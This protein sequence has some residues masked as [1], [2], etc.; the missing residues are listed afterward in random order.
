MTQDFYVKVCTTTAA[1]WPSTLVK[2]I[3]LVDLQKQL[4]CISNLKVKLRNIRGPESLVNCKSALASISKNATCPNCRWMATKKRGRVC[5]EGRARQ[6]GEQIP[7]GG[8][9]EWNR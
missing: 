9:N 6:D 3:T 7:R 8:D 1:P 5:K 4:A 2:C